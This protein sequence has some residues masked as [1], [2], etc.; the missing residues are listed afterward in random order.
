MYLYLKMIFMI[1]YINLTTKFYNI[2]ITNVQIFNNPQKYHSKVLQF[3]INRYLT[4]KIILIIQVIKENSLISKLQFTFFSLQQYDKINF[5]TEISNLS[6]R[7]SIIARKI[8]SLSKCIRF[9]MYIFYI[10]EVFV[11]TEFSF[12]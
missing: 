1:T 5:I 8:S 7:S 9:D 4:V 11:K 2:M 12:S 6:W 3:K 10:E